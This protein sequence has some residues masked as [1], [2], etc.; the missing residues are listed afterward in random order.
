MLFL[1]GVY[2]EDREGALSFRWVKAPTGAELIALASRIASHVGRF[3]ERQG[4]LER[5]REH[6]CLSELALEDEPMEDLLAHSITYRI[7]VGPRAGRKVFTLQTL[8]AGDETCSAVVD[9]L[10]GFSLHAGVAARADERKKLERLSAATGRTF[11]G[12]GRLD[13]SRW[14]PGTG[15]LSGLYSVEMGLELAGVPHKQG[16]VQTALNYLGECARGSAA[17]RKAA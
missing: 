13:T 4:L 16:G 6:P 5:D 9:R 12:A 7:A 15:P 11:Q 10:A 1:D 2:V 14:A 8:P 3:L 17:T